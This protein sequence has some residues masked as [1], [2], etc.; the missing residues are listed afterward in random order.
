MAVVNSVHIK[1]VRRFR[2]LKVKVYKTKTQ[3]K[4]CIQI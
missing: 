4:D 2:L 3:R 1:N